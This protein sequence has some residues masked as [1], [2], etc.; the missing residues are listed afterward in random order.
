MVADFIETFLCVC[1]FAKGH[2]HWLAVLCEGN[3]LS[4]YESGAF[5]VPFS[6]SNLAL[7]GVNVCSIG[8]VA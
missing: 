3:V 5:S 7:L 2:H 4:T 1:N 6:F 8:A